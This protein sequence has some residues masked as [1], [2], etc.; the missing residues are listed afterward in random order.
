MASPLQ[1][2]AT[3]WRSIS[4]S[5]YEQPN[6]QICSRNIRSDLPVSKC[7]LFP[8][9]NGIPVTVNIPLPKDPLAPA[10]IVLMGDNFVAPDGGAI[11]LQDLFVDGRIEEDCA[12]A[13]LDSRRHGESIPPATFDSPRP[14]LLSLPSL[15]AMSTLNRSPPRLSPPS[16]TSSPDALFETCITLS[17]NPSGDYQMRRM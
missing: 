15:S 16:L 17:C 2:T 13:A 14:N 8:I 9:Q 4:N 11:F 12:L 6:L 10:Q 1:L 7:N 3:V 5:P